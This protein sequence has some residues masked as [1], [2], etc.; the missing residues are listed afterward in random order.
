MIPIQDK[1]DKL[2]SVEDNWALLK[3]ILT[4]FV[5]TMRISYELPEDPSTFEVMKPKRGRKKTD[6]S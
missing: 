5:S 2:G 6:G 3:E 4:E 1:I